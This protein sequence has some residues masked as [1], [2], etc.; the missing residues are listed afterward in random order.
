MISVLC[1]SRGRPE[2]LSGSIGSLLSLASDMTG[3]EILVAA[4]PDDHATAGAVPAVAACWTAPE[5]YG[6]AQLHRYYNHLAA[7]ARGEWLL[8][9]ND[10]ARMLTRDWD[11]VIEGQE[12]GVLWPG[13]NQGPYFFPAWPKAWSDA[14]GH[15]SLSPNVDVWLSEV[16]SRLGLARPVP[17][18]IVHDRKDITGGH[19]DLTY[20]EGRA[21]MGAY[22]NH[23]DYDSAANREARIRDAIA[24]RRLLEGV[25]SASATA[26]RT[27]PAVPG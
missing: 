3:V 12:P 24:V 10:D 19:D 27:V 1:P 21:V 25:S 15:V 2:S 5:R 26:P 17:V 9:W 14:W 23:P 22:S 18:E 13:S 7:L 16:G 6:Y 4:D 11:K 8:L 20:A